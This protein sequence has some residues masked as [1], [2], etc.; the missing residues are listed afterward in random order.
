[1]VR[2]FFWINILSMVSLSTLRAQ[3][4]ALNAFWEKKLGGG[5]NL[6]LFE[7]YWHKSNDIL[8]EDI[9]SQLK[10]I[11]KAGF[12]TLRLPVAF[13]LFLQPNSSNLQPELLNKL[14]AI[15]EQCNH[16][17]LN[18]ILTYHYG[19]LTDS[20]IPGETDRISWIWKQIQ[21]HFRGKGY[22]SLFFELYNEPTLSPDQWA[23]TAVTLVS[24]LR[25]EDDQRVYII[26]GTNYNNIDELKNLPPID[27]KKLL[28]TFH[29]YD[30]YIF[31]HQ[32]A[33]WTIDKTYITGL[34]YPY[35]KS[36]MPAKPKKTKGTS[37]ERDYDKYPFEATKAYLSERIKSIA[38][39]CEAHNMPLICTET[40]VI[41]EAKLK[42]RKQYLADI[43]S[44]LH[45]NSI[46]TVLWDYDQNFSIKKNETSVLKCLRK[47]LK[48]LR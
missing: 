31:T 15:F 11:S 28:Y 30:P 25:Y 39:Y 48:T 24:Y 26:G 22:G 4:N 42:Y 43:T 38:D 19:K 20:N 10:N 40:G 3:P 36:K 29:F 14:S 23:K 34:P 41:D 33:S 2:L 21:N 44:I 47:W 17:H 7:Q 32:G 35:Q 46:A 1:M 12:S 5:V 45:M 18:L 8:Q 16:F 37:V 13:D 9:T 6:S 27:D